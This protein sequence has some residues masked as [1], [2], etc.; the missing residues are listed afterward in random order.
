M[1]LRDIPGHENYSIS[2]TGII[3]KGHRELKLS[4]TKCGYLKVG[5][6]NDSKVKTYRVHR[7]VMLTF[8]GPSELSVNHIDGNKINNDLSNL[9]YCTH[10]ENCLHAF[11]LGL[12]SCLGVKNSQCKL[13]EAKVLEVREMYESDPNVSRISRATG[14]NRRT[15]SD[16][17]RRVRWAH[18]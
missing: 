11:R 7:L 14:I 17:V 6:W 2:D 18:I 3:L 8:I 4:R 12:K 16:I 10:S 5:L 13:T 15:L 9:E 1:N